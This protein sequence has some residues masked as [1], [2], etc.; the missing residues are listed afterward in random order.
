MAVSSRRTRLGHNQICASAQVLLVISVCTTA[1][2]AIKCNRETKQ[3]DYDVEGRQVG[4]VA[5]RQVGRQTRGERC[6]GGQT[7]TR[8]AEQ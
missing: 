4:Q 7:G 6:A 8:L 5:G 3:R 2:C 1:S